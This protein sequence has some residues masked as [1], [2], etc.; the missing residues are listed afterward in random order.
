VELRRS[1]LKRCC[2]PKKVGCD[3]T[4]RA[5]CGRII[6]FLTKTSDSNAHSQELQR[7]SCRHHC[8]C[9][10]YQ[11]TDCVQSRRISAC[12]SQGVSTEYSVVIYV[13]VVPSIQSLSTPHGIL[14]PFL[15]LQEMCRNSLNHTR[16][17][18]FTNHQP[19]V[20]RRQG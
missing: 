9:V 20:R 10:A 14:S 5:G 7:R 12:S 16:H 4:Q 6:Y 13:R 19:K 1:G 17:A 18:A 11:A 2:V 8:C 15:I 3:V